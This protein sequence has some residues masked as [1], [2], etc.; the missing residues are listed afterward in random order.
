M[1]S[2]F[3]L[4]GEEFV[5]DGHDCPLGDYPSV[6]VPVG[7]LAGNIVACYTGDGRT[8]LLEIS[9]GARYVH[10]NQTTTSTLRGFDPT[11]HGLFAFDEADVV[12]YDLGTERAF[13]SRLL[14]S[15]AAFY[16]EPFYRLSLALETDDSS[17]IRPLY[18]SCAKQFIRHA[19]EFLDGWM[20]TLASA[21]GL[22]PPIQRQ[23]L[24]RL[25]KP[26]LERSAAATR[27]AISVPL[28]KP[29]LPRRG[30]SVGPEMDE[31][32]INRALTVLVLDDPSLKIGRRDAYAAAI[33]E[34]LGILA[35]PLFLEELTSHRRTPSS[36][37]AALVSG[38]SLPLL[39]FRNIV[40]GKEKAVEFLQLSKCSIPANLLLSEV[41]DSRVYEQFFK[42]AAVKIRRRLVFTYAEVLS[43]VGYQGAVASPAWVG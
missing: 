24:S 4:R 42:R 35:R 16:I 2:E 29:E 7:N 12:I 36:R 27:E 26:Q 20:Q 9:P 5:L 23:W 39:E 33:Q 32:T 37:E 8:Q 21:S 30:F 18:F 38:L 14:R 41:L 25:E 28:A 19:P 22:V 13:Y 6:A 43:L 11:R 15:S 17:L 34:S 31:L 10:H 40:L 1:T 3:N